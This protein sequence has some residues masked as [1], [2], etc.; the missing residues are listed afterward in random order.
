MEVEVEAMEAVMVGFEVEAVMVGI[1][2]EAM[3]MEVNQHPP[4]RKPSS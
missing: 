1:E 3:A 2:V 4:I